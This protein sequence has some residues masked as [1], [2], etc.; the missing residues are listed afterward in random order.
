MVTQKRVRQRGFVT[1]ELPI[2]F[3]IFCLL[4]LVLAVTTGMAFN[5][6]WYWRVLI[7]LAFVGI[8]VGWFFA[9]CFMDSRRRNR[10]AEAKLE[11]DMQPPNKDSAP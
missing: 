4:C 11:R 9:Y 6:A 7:G 1:N 3:G 2:V 10:K 8:G 5:L